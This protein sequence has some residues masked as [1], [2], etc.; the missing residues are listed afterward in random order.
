M[1]DEESVEKI[2]EI[3]LKILKML[4][5][6]SRISF[7]NLAKKI[8]ISVGTAYNRIKNLERKGIIKTYT[9]VVDPY[10][11]GL[12]LTAI[13]L[14]QAEGAHLTEVEEE[15]AKNENVICVYDIT[16]DFDIAVIARFKDR[17]RL[18]SFVKN[19]IS[20]PHVK[21]TVTNVVLNVVKENFKVSLT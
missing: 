14:V 2:D 15:I 17:N 11:L 20:I 6:D 18:N 7:H 5:E 12:T 9:A 3:D 10:K 8:G 1:N 4:Q 13:I 21:R 16:G 19:L